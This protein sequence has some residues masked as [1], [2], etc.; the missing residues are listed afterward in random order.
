MRRYAYGLTHPQT[1]SPMAFRMGDLHHSVCFVFRVFVHC[2]FV[3]R[4]AAMSI[5]ME[6]TAHPLRIG[7][8]H[9]LRR[10]CVRSDVAK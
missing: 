1:I 2:V 6:H 7:W 9:H 8:R 5:R 10:D 4:T 3:C